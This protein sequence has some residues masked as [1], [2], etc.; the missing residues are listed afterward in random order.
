MK[1]SKVVSFTANSVGQLDDVHCGLVV[2]PFETTK[3]WSQLTWHLQN[4]CSV[5]LE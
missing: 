1:S 4:V 5:I 2:R 3:L